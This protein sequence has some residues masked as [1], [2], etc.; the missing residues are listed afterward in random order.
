M[1][2]LGQALEALEAAGLVTESRAADGSAPV[3]SVTCDSRQ[4]GPGALFVCKG[5]AFQ[6]EYLRQAL[7]RG[8]AAYVSEVCY[9]V[10]GAP[11]R[12]LVSDVRAAMAVLGAWFYRGARDAFRLIGIT[13]TKGK[14]TA[15]YFIK[16]ILDDYLAA[17]RRPESAILS[18]LE[19]YDGLR[20]A[21]AALTTPEP[22]DLHAH[23]ARAAE[24]KIPYF[25]MEVSSQALKT[26]RTAGV[27][28]DAGC[29]LNFGEDH[30]SPAEHPD[31]EDYFQSK[32]KLPAQCDTLC[33]NLG[34]ARADRVL[35]AARAAR[36]VITFGLDERADVY[37]YGVAKAG[38]ALRFRVRTARFDRPF[39]IT[40]PG[41]FNVENALAAIAVCT[42]LEIPE[43]HIYMGLCKARAGGRMEAY[44][45]ADGRVTA[46]VDYAHNA[47]SF[48]ALFSSVA[49]EYPGRA[50]TAVF[51][52]PGGKAHS[53]RQ[54]LGEI[55]GRYA[56]RVI[57]TE[58][59]PGPESAADICREIA[60]HVGDTPCEIIEDRGAAI[61]AAI[62]GAEPDAV[63][64]IAGKG[65]EAAQRRGT[66]RVPC[67]SDAARARGALK[68]YNRE[69]RLDPEELADTLTCVLPSLRALRGRT[70]VVAPAG[71]ALEEETALDALCADIALLRAAGARVAVTVPPGEAAGLSEA[72]KRHEETA[73]DAA[74]ADARTLE[75]MLTAGALPVLETPDPAALAASLKADALICLRDSAGLVLDP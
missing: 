15:A 44:S 52:A 30:I 11:G 71:A 45:S 29:F 26:G 48:E 50:V 8:A 40:V 65:H 33:V 18:T 24:A 9:D 51:G 72:L 63:V 5:A 39:S 69:R 59:D 62:L 60:A 61:E 53:R 23:F 3:S 58:D 36:R 47:M 35:E 22:L 38:D 73:A 10:P 66:E 2:T 64:I 14:S 20:R 74:G 4:A 31:L 27:R 25:T 12:I 42:A 16:F 21:P 19:T 46:I 7:E 57:L 41:L 6:P 49:R 75:R 28:F 37:G 17:D 56:G 32:L 70:A 67:L 68:T 54:S 43:R 13:G 34:T 1:R 55:A